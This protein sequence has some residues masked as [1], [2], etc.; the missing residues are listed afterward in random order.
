MDSP[1]L[2]HAHRQTWR[3]LADEGAAIE[4]IELRERIA[5]LEADLTIYREI[6][7]AGIHHAHTARLR[8]RRLRATATQYRHE[9]AVLRAQ[10]REAQAVRPTADSR[11]A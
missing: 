2:P 5:S 9:I 3:D 6:A 1:N 4:I 11:A 7:Q 10:L 8:E